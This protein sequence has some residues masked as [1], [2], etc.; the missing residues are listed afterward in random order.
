MAKTQVVSFLLFTVLILSIDIMGVVGDGK[1]CK[2]I[3]LGGCKLGVDD[4]R[5]DGKCF[6]YCTPECKFAHCQSNQCHCAC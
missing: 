4:E 3:S 6:K 1:C 5:P 2:N